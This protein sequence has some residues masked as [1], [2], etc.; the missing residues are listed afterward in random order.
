M[1]EQS[2][3]YFHKLGKIINIAGT[4][5]ILFTGYATK[6]DICHVWAAKLLNTASKY[7]FIKTK[8]EPNLN[9]VIV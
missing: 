8:F 5:Q 3:R 7:R 4:K 2:H 6:A 9:L 1:L